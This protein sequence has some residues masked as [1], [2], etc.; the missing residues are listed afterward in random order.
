MKRLTTIELLDIWETYMHLSVIERSLYLLST[1]YAADVSTIAMMSIGERDA[2]L[3][4]F[5]KWIFGS[6]LINMSYCPQ[7]AEPIEWETDIE[8]I[9]LQEVLPESPTRILELEEDGFK[10]EFRLPNSYDMLAAVSNPDGAKLMSRCILK[11]KQDKN[12]YS[13]EEL[14]QK[15]IEGISECMS[16]ADPQADI[17][18]VL[19]CPGCK[20]QWEAPFD[21]LHYLWIEIESWAKRIIKEVAVLARAF[22]W[23]E[24]EI[25]NLSPQRRQLYL[26][27]ISR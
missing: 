9:R 7:C 5:R 17:K 1:V 4:E 13:F 19:S 24:K 21:I 10:I 8:D 25:L 6:R 12:E 27:I 15:I 11:I 23:S 14:P 18:M 22:G 16:I 3:L 26:E 2:R 20:N